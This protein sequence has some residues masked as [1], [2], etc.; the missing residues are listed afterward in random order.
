MRKLIVPAM[1]RLL[2]KFGWEGQRVYRHPDGEVWRES[3]LDAEVNVPDFND[4]RLP[5]GT[6]FFGELYLL[7]EDSRALQ[8]ELR[9]VW[10]RY[11]DKVERDSPVHKKYALEVAFLKLEP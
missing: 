3:A 8:R 7:D 2:R 4:P 10:A 11:A 1:A 6:Q 9:D 5:V